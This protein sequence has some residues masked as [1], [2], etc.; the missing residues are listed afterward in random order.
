MFSLCKTHSIQGS[1]QLT[2]R[3]MNDFKPEHYACRLSVLHD[4]LCITS[5]ITLLNQCF[6][7]I[8]CSKAFCETLVLIGK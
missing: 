2:P 4:N 1:Y 5:S 3:L 8:A 7:N 6:D